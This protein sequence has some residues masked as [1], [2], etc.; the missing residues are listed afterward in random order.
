MQAPLR[1]ALVALVGFGVACGGARTDAPATRAPETNPAPSPPAP[2][3]TSAADPTPEKP[4]ED[5]PSAA[6]AEATGEAADSSRDP[7][8]IRDVRYTAMPD[9]LKIEVD[10]VRFLAKAE[11]IRTPNGFNVRVTVSATASEGRSLLAP[12]NGPLAFAGS[13][14]RAGKP[15]AET[16]GDERQGDG[17]EPLGE[18]TT[19]KLSRDF[20]PKGVRPLGNGDVLELDV[21]LWGLGTGPS[22]RRAVKL[23]ARVKASVASWKGKASVSPPPSLVGK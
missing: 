20:P 21:G 5:A 17:E 8:K 6:P 9:A 3:A 23:F 22:D 12:K 4:A 7:D 11:P 2:E 1:Y 18:G 14:K 13:V 10:G 16:F 19:V 15:E